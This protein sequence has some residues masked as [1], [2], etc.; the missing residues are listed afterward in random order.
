MKKQYVILVHILIWLLIFGPF[1]FLSLIIFDELQDFYS[2]HFPN[3][4]LHRPTLVKSSFKS[5]FTF[6]IIF[7]T[8]YFPIFHFL[9]RGK[10]NWKK[11]S[12]ALLTFVTLFFVIKLS[13]RLPF[14]KMVKQQTQNFNTPVINNRILTNTVQVIFILIVGGFG[15]AFRS[16]IQFLNERRKRKELE[17]TNLKSEINM[18]RSQVNPH[19]IFNTLNNIDTLIKKDPDKASD[20]KVIGK[21]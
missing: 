21:S 1:S 7:Y 16:F 12:L 9:F 14:V 17:T 10:I 2:H 13:D 8:F 11:L 15:I 4:N 5:L 3:I 18:L 19:F 20:L 6:V